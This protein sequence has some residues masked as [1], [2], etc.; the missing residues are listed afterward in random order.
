MVE[1]L[2]YPQGD[3]DTSRSTSN[4]HPSQIIGFSDGVLPATAPD[5]AP[6]S[7]IWGNDA[8]LASMPPAGR[9]MIEPSF[10][11]TYQLRS[12]RRSRRAGMTRVAWAG[13]IPSSA[14]TPRS[15]SPRCRL[16][17]PAR[18]LR[19]QIMSKEQT[20]ET[21]LATGVPTDHLTTKPRTPSTS[22]PANCNH[23]S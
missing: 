18:G 13:P 10:A 21:L 6:A 15:S 16:P 17:D 4:G 1:S 11:Y 7:G 12:P 9:T 5:D 22:S 8:N 14:S 23:W 20:C 3:G 2:S 19:R